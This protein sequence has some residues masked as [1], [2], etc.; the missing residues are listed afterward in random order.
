MVSGLIS[1]SENDE[2]LFLYF[3]VGT[4]WRSFTASQN[5]PE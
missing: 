3:L 2:E 5:K 1:E 4:K